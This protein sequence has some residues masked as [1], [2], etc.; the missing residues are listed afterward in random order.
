M[1]LPTDYERDE[2]RAREA[3]KIDREID[4]ADHD[5]DRKRDDPPE[6]AGILAEWLQEASLRLTDACRDDY[7]A[8]VSD[9]RA[10]T[11]LKLRSIL[12]TKYECNDREPN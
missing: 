9:E 12:D 8:G 11:V 6:I 3:A 7:D 5:R 4:K 1:P 2:R 10:R